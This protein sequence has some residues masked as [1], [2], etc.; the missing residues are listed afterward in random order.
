MDS[1]GNSIVVWTSDNQDG[2][3]SGVYAQR[4]D[5]S[6]APQG[7]EFRVNVTTANDQRQPSVAMT[8]DG[9]FVVVW[10]GY[11]TATSSYDVYARLY[12][13]GATSSTGELLVNTYTTSSQ[14]EPSVALDSSGNF[15]VVWR[16][17][18]QDGDNGGIYAQR[19]D[20]AGYTIGSELTM[21]ASA[22]GHQT[23]PQI[24]MRD[25]GEF[26]VTWATTIGW[27]PPDY[28]VFLRYFDSTGSPQTGDLQVNQ[29]TTN[30]QLYQ[31][32]AMDSSGNVT[33]VWSS[34]GQDGSGT[35]VY[36][37]RYNS[38]GTALG[39]EYQVNV[40]TTSAQSYPMIAMK[41]DG[42]HVI[43]WTTAQSGTDDI[44]MRVVDDTGTSTG[45]LRV[46]SQLADTQEYSC[47]AMDDAGD[48]LIAWTTIL[49]GSSQEIAAQRYFYWPRVESVTCADSNPTSASTVDYLVTFSHPVSGVDLSDFDLASTGLS[50][51]SVSSVSPAGSQDV[52]TVTVNTGSGDGTLRLDALDDDTI[53]TSASVPLGGGGLDTGDFASGESYML[54]RLKPSSS[55]TTATRHM[56]MPS[57]EFFVLS[58]STDGTTGSGVMGVQLWYRKVGSTTYPSYTQYGGLWTSD[59][60]TFDTSAIAEGGMGTYEFYTRAQDMAGNLEDAPSSAQLSV[61]FDPAAPVTLSVLRIE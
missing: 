7:T 18:G 21:H 6:G 52:Y 43:T 60:I 11:N 41:D 42:K 58:N 32:A 3:G 16:S 38:S 1:T 55:A 2:G 31:C 59:W 19:F 9:R 57:P 46:N 14:D 44:Y 54:D 51:A 40:T 15:V 35:G 22:T 25:S 47:V 53:V 5:S 26:I 23:A 4:Y 27:S 8:S 33:V 30:F 48:F 37:R 50:G 12:D 13:T 36:A 17:L 45:E 10:S 39:N 34:D 61:L 20:A 49:C 56:V 24:A 29:Y 28:D